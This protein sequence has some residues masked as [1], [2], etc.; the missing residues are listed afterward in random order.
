M[1]VGA[2]EEEELLLAL[3]PHDALKIIF[4]AADGLDVRGGHSDAVLLAIGCNDQ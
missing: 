4:K 2:E 3:D 1:H